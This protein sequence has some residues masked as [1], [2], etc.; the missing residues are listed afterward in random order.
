VE[1]AIAAAEQLVAA[2]NREHRRAAVDRLLQRLRLPCQVLRDEQ[3]LAVLA[4]TDVVEVLL[5]GRDRVSHSHC[6]HV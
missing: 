6:G 3:L 1:T 4:A 2:T 5:A